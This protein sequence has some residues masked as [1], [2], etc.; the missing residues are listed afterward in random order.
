MCEKDFHKHK[1]VI[2]EFTMSNSASDVVLCELQKITS[3]VNR[4]FETLTQLCGDTVILEQ[5]GS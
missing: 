4:T 2:K 1:K 3:E 5:G